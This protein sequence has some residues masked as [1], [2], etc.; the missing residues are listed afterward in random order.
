[1]CESVRNAI[2]RD[3]RLPG[4]V[5]FDAAVA[6]RDAD[7]L[8]RLLNE[9]WFGVPESEYVRGEAGFFELC[10]L[11]EGIDRGEEEFDA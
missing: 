3:S 1:V 8:L 9:T 6:V 4:V 2:L 7:V 10:D 5:R 11:C